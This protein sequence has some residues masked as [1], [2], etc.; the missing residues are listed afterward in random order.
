MTLN[1]TFTNSNG[2]ASVVNN[3]LPQILFGQTLYFLYDTRSRYFLK[4]VFIDKYLWPKYFLA[5]SLQLPCPLFFVVD[6]VQY[7]N[8]SFSWTFQ[9]N[10]STMSTDDRTNVFT[11]VY[12]NSFWLPSISSIFSSA[13]WLEREL[14]DFTGIN[15]VG[16]LDTRRLLLDYFEEKQVWQTHISNDKNFNN[17]LYD[18]FLSF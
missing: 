3:A 4:T 12:S 11:K 13:L 7:V 8:T 18:S 16:L 5:A 9:F 17:T 2:V 10:S 6:G 15:F 1:K 14:S